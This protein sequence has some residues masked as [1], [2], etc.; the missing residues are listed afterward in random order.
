MSARFDSIGS[1]A[2][3]SG[4]AF[5]ETRLIEFDKTAFPEPT[6]RRARASLR[7]R[8][9]RGIG[10]AP[11][12]SCIPVQ[13]REL[14]QIGIVVKQRREVSPRPDLIAEDAVDEDDG[15]AVLVVLVPP[16]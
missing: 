3:L 5:A 9:S 10:P 6:R 13:D 4:I 14:G 1:M 12:R 16:G 8:G 2:G 11:V 15:V 7:P